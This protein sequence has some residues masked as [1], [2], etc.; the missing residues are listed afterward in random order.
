VRLMHT[1]TPEASRAC[2]CSANMSS[3]TIN[4]KAK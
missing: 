2:P 1:P 3:A 4:Y